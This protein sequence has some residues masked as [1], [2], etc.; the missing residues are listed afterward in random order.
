MATI[1]CLTFIMGSSNVQIVMATC[2][3]SGTT[4]KRH[5]LS[6]GRTR[7]KHCGIPKPGKK[8]RPRVCLSCGES[9]TPAAHNQ[10]YCST[11]HQNLEAQ[12]RWR[13]RA[14]AA[15]EATMDRL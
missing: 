7:C 11:E 14:Q 2:K 5:D 6:A 9:F 15:M 8:R 3:R 12:R 4:Y 10:R 13:E 1:M